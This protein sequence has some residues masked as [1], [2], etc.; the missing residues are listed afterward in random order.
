[1]SYLRKK[2]DNGYDP[3]R[4]RK[5]FGGWIDKSKD[6]KGCFGV[7]LLIGLAPFGVWQAGQWL[8]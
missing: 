5:V 8:F 1:M 3:R 7:L 6:R 2:K 4:H